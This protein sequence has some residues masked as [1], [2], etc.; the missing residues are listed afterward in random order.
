MVRC[1][2]GTSMTSAVGVN[3][4]R[5]RG[6]DLFGHPLGL[7]VLMAIELFW[8]YAN[9][10]FEF[11]LT[12]YLTHHLLLPGQVE[13]VIGFSAYRGLLQGSG[14]PLSAVDIA[15]QTYGVYT[16]VS[17]ALPLLGAILADRWMGQG[18]A[19][20]VGLA[21]L[22][23]AFLALIFEQTFIVGLLLFFVG[24]GL[25]RCN[26]MVQIGRLYAI[27]DPRRTN[28]FG[29]FLV[30]AN[31][32]S[33]ASPLIAGSLVEKV[34][35]HAGYTTL[36]FAIG[37]GLIA[38]GVGRNHLPPDHIR[39]QG[40]GTAKPPPMTARDLRVSLV[41]VLVL[42]PNILHFAAYN[43][44]FNIFPIWASDHLDHTI[45][46]FT[47]PVTW[48]SA[49]DGLLTVVGVMIAMRI[50]AWDARRP[51]PMGDFTRMAIGCSLG[52]LGFA[53]LALVAL[54][55]G[56]APLIAGI[57][58]FVFA[59]PAIT[60]VDT[61]VLAL[62]SRSAPVA[63]CATLVGV[64]NLSNA[65]GYFLTGQLGR[66]YGHMT[67]AAFWSVHIGLDAAALLFLALAG[68]PI[69]RMLKSRHVDA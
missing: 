69:A 35:F 11:S 63:V 33:F 1:C 53:I 55:P 64:Y 46:G 66:L 68:P 54:A 50:W 57:G 58:F 41:L 29:L 16:G 45:L 21:V 24:S 5:T 9:T 65:V 23:V 44:A 14:P 40:K 30:A 32:G 19:M 60:W 4:P 7:T 26:L 51:R 6:G 56:K 2:G 13:D 42:V 10:G 59:D 15:S 22:V 49:L 36:A 18:R 39:G 47:M 28:A 8:A 3:L 34:S 67:P 25:L 12:L 48:F 37:A 17:R 62:I 43:Q 61:I 27:D 20:A 38:Y 52:V 31:I